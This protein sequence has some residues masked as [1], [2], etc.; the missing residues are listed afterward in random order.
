VRKSYEKSFSSKKNY[1]P[2]IAHWFFL[3]VSLKTKN[4]PDP[5]L[6]DPASLELRLTP[7]DAEDDDTS[8]LSTWPRASDGGLFAFH[9]VPRGRVYSL[10]VS[11]P[12][13]VFPRVLVEVKEEEEEEGGGGGGEGGGGGGGGSGGDNSDPFRAW[14]VAPLA[15]V[16]AAVGGSPGNNGVVTAPRDPTATS[17]A[18]PLPLERATRKESDNGGETAAAAPSLLVLRPT[19][20]AT[21]FETPQP[22][23]VVAFLKTPY[24][25]LIGFVAFAVFALPRMKI[26]PEEYEELL[27]GGGAGGGAGGANGNNAAAAPS[28]AS[29]PQQQQRQ[30][31]AGGR[32]SSSSP[33]GLRQR[34]G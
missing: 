26:D 19:A 32:P 2:P 20:R 23:N 17:T 34:R 28:S 3:S 22:F 11:S 31:P 1:R 15:D 8:S 25:M 16:A 29:P 33:S 6:A 30:L 18:V 4:A 27:G 14:L 9:G 21:Y 7:L 5:A 12:S 13:L 24:G 10:D